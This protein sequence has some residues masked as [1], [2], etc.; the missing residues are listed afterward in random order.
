MRVLVGGRP[1]LSPAGPLSCREIDESCGGLGQ[2]LPPPLATH[3]P[4]VSRVG[5]G[6]GRG[7]QI[8]SLLYVQSLLVRVKAACW[9]WGEGGSTAQHPINP[10]MAGKVSVGVY[11]YVWSVVGSGVGDDRG[12]QITA[13]CLLSS[14]Q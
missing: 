8:T 2:L 10:Y 14:V 1:I 9:G 11:E 13:S 7:G 6:G 3:P 4:Q 12:W 5:G